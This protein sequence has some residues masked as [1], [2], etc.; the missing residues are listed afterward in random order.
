MLPFRQLLKPDKKFDWTDELDKLFQESRLVIIAEIKEGIRIFDVTWEEH[1]INTLHRQ[2]QA[3]LSHNRLVEGRD[4]LLPFPEALQMP[5]DC[6]LMLPWRMEIDSGWQPVHA[7]S[8]ILL[9][10]Q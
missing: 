9:C 8:R 5:I 6:T 3:D 4:R 7:P 1:V 10:S 2:E